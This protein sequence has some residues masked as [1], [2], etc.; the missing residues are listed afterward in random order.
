MTD[1]TAFCHALGLRP[2]VVVPDGKWRRCPTEAH[3]RKRN[4]AY[5]LAPDGSVGWAQDWSTMSEPATWRASGKN[6][7]AFDAREYRQRQEEAQ[8]ASEHATAEARE[9]YELAKPLRGGHPYLEAHGLDMRGC[10]GLKVDA[11]GWL[12][13]PALRRG[14]LQSLQRISPDGEKRFWYGASV[15]GTS[16]VVERRDAVVTVL[17]E[18]LATGLACYRS[19]SASRVVVAWNAG[20]LNAVDVGNGMLVIA[21]DND[22]ET[23]ARIGRN[24]GLEAARKAAEQYG[25]GIAYPTGI[26][27]SDWCDYL[28]ERTADRMATKGRYTTPAAVRQSVEGEVRSALLRE[29]RLRVVA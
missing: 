16:Y 29:A 19:L 25:C 4:G 21:A 2:G 3:P 12:V 7:L 20:N 28:L 22:H 13:V 18:G 14:A 17:C 5:K 10:E 26:H 11:K 23:E 6:A 8:R 24:P 27:G 15:A 9:F 1:F